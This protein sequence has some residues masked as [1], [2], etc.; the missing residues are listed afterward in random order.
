MQKDL[1]ATSKFE[2][3]GREVPEKALVQRLQ[4]WHHLVKRVAEE[5]PCQQLLD[6]G[7][8][9]ATPLPPTS[10]VGKL[11]GSA[12][13]RTINAAKAAEKSRMIAREN[14][15]EDMRRGGALAH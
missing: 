3:G 12:A 4:R 8:W 15:Q 6:A 5:K 7:R 14:M 13:K 11:A 1:K 10:T 9:K 2:A